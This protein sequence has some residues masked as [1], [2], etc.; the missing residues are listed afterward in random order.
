MRMGGLSEKLLELLIRSGQKSF[1]VAPEG[2]SQKI[3][4]ILQKDISEEEIDRALKLGV[5]VGF[6]KIKMYFIYG[7]P[8]ET[9]EDLKDIIRL[10]LHAKKMGYELK[11]SLNPLI[12]KPGTPFEG[13]KMEDMKILRE[14]EKF[15]KHFFKKIGIEFHFESIRKSLLQYKI[16]NADENDIVEIIIRYSPITKQ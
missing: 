14:K 11:V 10:A 7:V 6:K 3:R 12:P 8:G 9:D 1:T 5:K 15:L 13:E 16:A 2:G 4:N